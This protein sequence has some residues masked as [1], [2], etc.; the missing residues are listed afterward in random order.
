ME[1]S[2]ELVVFLVASWSRYLLDLSYCKSAVSCQVAFLGNSQCDRGMDF[3][4]SSWK[5]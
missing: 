5:Q 3:A 2:I 4:C 1:G